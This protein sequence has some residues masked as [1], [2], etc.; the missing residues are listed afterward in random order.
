[1]ITLYIYI[2]YTYTCIHPMISHSRIPADLAKS[3]HITIFAAR[4]LYLH[5]AKDIP[6]IKDLCDIINYVLIL[7]IN[8]KRWDT[9]QI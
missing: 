7:Y 4:T 2:L 6:M 3:A 8:I 5:S 9:H 1:M